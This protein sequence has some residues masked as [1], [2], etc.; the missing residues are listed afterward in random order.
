MWCGESDRDWCGVRGATRLEKNHSPLVQIPWQCASFTENT[1]GSGC[2]AVFVGVTFCARANTSGYWS[3][4]WQRY[5][6]AL[7]HWR[8]VQRPRYAYTLQGWAC[9]SLYELSRCVC[10]LFVGYPSCEVDSKDVADLT[11]QDTGAGVA[12]AIGIFLA[13]GGAGMSCSPWGSNMGLRR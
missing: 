4:G 5:I 1:P 3:L 13:W 6:A 7:E 12:R 2:R 10:H 8:P 11:P 9:P